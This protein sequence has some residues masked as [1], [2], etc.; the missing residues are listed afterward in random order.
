MS[1]TRSPAD[2]LARPPTE[3][4]RADPSIHPS[5]CLAGWLARAAVENNQPI[6]N[7][8]AAAASAT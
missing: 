6:N 1:D 5:G 3:E 8:A 7:G 4:R 2:S